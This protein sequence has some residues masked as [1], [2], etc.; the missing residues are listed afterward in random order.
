MKVRVNLNTPPPQASPL[1]FLLVAGAATVPGQ[2]HRLASEPYG[3][4]SFRE[5]QKKWFPLGS[6][7]PG[8]QQQNNGGFF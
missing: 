5:L 2:P 6:W 1:M 3:G 8:V 7:R 4:K